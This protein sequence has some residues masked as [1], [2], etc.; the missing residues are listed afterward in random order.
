MTPLAP[1]GVRAGD[2]RRRRGPQ[3]RKSSEKVTGKYR[4]G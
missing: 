2:V 1:Q 3:M 4:P